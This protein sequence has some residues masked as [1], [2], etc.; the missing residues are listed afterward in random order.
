MIVTGEKL[1]AQ[2]CLDWG[3]CNRVV[4]ADTLLEDTIAWATEIAGRAPLSMRY[5]KQSVNKALEAS[6]GDIISEEA[7]LQH[8]CITSEDAK[9]G[10]A[11]FMQ[12]RAPEWKG[13]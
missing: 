5:A 11:A 7:K 3:L 2:K 4:P 1:S 10:A 9:E 12:K 6:V 13:R 8:L